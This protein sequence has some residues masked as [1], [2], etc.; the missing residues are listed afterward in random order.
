MSKDWLKLTPREAKTLSLTVYGKDLNSVLVQY[1]GIRWDDK[2]MN[3]NWIKR[4]LW[5]TANF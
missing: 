3:G 2:T 4:V 5:L 1:K